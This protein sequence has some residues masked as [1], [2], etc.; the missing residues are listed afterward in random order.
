MK[1]LT[2]II[3]TLCV[4]CINSVF[5]LSN[6]TAEIFRDNMVLQRDKQVA[7]WGQ[8][9]DGY[10]VVVAFDGQTKTNTSV[11]GEWR[12][13]LDPMGANAVGQD[14]TVKFYYGAQLTR[15]ITLSNILV[16]DVYLAGGQSNMEL[17][18][19]FF[20]PGQP[21]INNNVIRFYKHPRRDAWGD[22][23][24]GPSQWTVCANDSSTKGISGVAY[25]FATEL[26]PHAGVPIG[27]LTSSV[28]ASP[29]EAWMSEE[30]LLSDPDFV[31]ILDRINDATITP[32]Y[33]QPTILYNQ[34]ISTML[35]FTLTGFIWYQGENNANLNPLVGA[36]AYRDLFPTLIDQWR[37]DFESPDAHFFF[38]Q[39]ASFGGFDTNSETFGNQT[40]WPVLRE[41]QYL[42]L[43]VTNTGMACSL[44]LGEKYDIHPH[45]KQE[46]GHRLSLLARERIYQE[47]LVSSGPTLIDH[48]VVGNKVVLYFDNIGSGLTVSNGLSLVGFEIAANDRQ[49]V[50]A[51]ATIV[52]NTVEVTGVGDP[53]YVR[54][55]WKNWPKFSGAMVN[56]YNNE[57][58]PATSFRTEYTVNK[59]IPDVTIFQASG[60]FSGMQGGN[61]WYYQQYNGS[62]YTDMVWDANNNRWQGSL[63][64]LQIFPSACHPAGGI[65]AVRVW[66]ATEF[67]A[68]TITGA[69]SKSGLTAGNGVIALIYKNTNLLW[70]ATIAPDTTVIPTGVANIS[71][72]A[73]DRLFFHLNDNGSATSDYTNWDPGVEFISV[74]APEVGISPVSSNNIPLV[75]VSWRSIAGINYQMQGCS[76]L[77]ENG[78]VDVGNPVL[79]SGG[80]V[81][82]TTSPVEAIGFYRIKCE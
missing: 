30:A 81:S 12:I 23:T 72:H 56:L 74:S 14:M 24:A 82:V 45:T 38:V 6:N 18:Y 73:G 21:T 78:W 10:E 36:I 54:Y 3:C 13:D 19:G 50:A 79:G 39:L 66:E 16:G 29:I 67:G 41:A 4:I 75:K 61:N 40:T 70:S 48:E 9:P 51:V 34:M 17:S 46:V 27:V 11:A 43:S 2:L 65:N 33:K 68:A 63:T 26:Q 8:A 37:N 53:V 77:V 35:P 58:L 44:D 28:G 49:Y 7:V 22:Q 25:C 47:S 62:T 32:D 80:T 20:Y 69:V 52:G 55:G 15:T 1:K 5:G 59:P 60:G 57:G 42:T 31:P 64:Y 71:V 76:N